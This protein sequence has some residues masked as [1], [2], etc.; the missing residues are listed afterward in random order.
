[1][2]VVK[3]LVER[4]AYSCDRWKKFQLS[5]CSLRRIPCRDGGIDEPATEERYFKYLRAMVT[6]D[7]L[8]QGASLQGPQEMQVTTLEGEP[9]TFKVFPTDTLTDLKAMLVARKH[10][11]DLTERKLCC[12]KVLAGGLLIDGDQ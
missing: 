4:L 1:M 3:V 12:V 5:V 11:E 8:L 7:F 10:R 6:P 2:D 9:L